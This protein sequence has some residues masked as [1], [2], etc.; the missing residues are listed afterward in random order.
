MIKREIVELYGK[1]I[2]RFHSL[3][4]IRNL[5]KRRQD[6][7]LSI[8]KIIIKQKLIELKKYYQINGNKQTLERYIIIYDYYAQREYKKYSKKRTIECCK[9]IYNHD[10]SSLNY[11]KR[12]YG[13]N[14][15]AVQKYEENCRNVISNTKIEYYL[16]K[17]MSYEEA[18]KDRSERQRTFTLEK[19]QKKYGLQKGKEVWKARQQKWQNTLNSKPEEEINDINRRKCEWLKDK[20]KLAKAVEKS[21]KAVEKLIE[22]DPELYCQIVAKR[23]EWQ[24][25][26][27]KV[28][29][30]NEK[31]KATLKKMKEENPEL[32]FQK[33]KRLSLSELCAVESEGYLYYLH[34]YNNDEDYYKIGITKYSNIK[35]R[36]SI[37]KFK[38]NHF[39]FDVLFFKKCYN[40]KDAYIHEQNILQKFGEYRIIVNYDFFSSTEVFNRDVFEGKYDEINI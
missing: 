16:Q 19:C 15:I 20:D 31:H 24:K 26:K 9:P 7:N 32:F 30:A 22:E 34:I 23:C 17:G 12:K 3:E 2:F 40:Y 37:N 14:E 13:D 33:F 28:A 21:A 5:I 11:F 36:W 1:D 39:N 29:E 8:D 27:D 35:Y 25:D 38:K 6:N 10:S 18:C 4:A